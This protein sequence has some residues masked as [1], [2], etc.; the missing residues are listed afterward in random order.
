VPEQDAYKNGGRG[1]YRNVSLVNVWATAPFMHNNAIGPELCGKPRNPK[2]DFFR[3]RYVDLNGQLIAEQPACFQYDATVDGRL[4]LYA[5]SMH[6]LLNPKERGIKMTLTDQDIIVDLGMRTWDGKQEKALFGSGKLTVPKGTSAGFIGGLLHKEFIGDL[7]RAKR[8]PALLE[9]AGKTGLVPELQS[10]AD[11]LLK[12]PGRFVDVLKQKR[13]FLQTNYQTCMQEVE[14]EG[15]RFGE[16][17]S[18][19]DKKALIAFMATL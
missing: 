12:D 2:N 8:E 4:R 11:D 6:E 1:Y 14:N 16:D 18:E 7:Y 10:I 3:A 5:Q 15:H 17:L 13:G 9:A 19:A